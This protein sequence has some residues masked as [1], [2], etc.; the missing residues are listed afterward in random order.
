M[1]VIVFW[2]LDP[3]GCFQ[4]LLDNDS[5]PRSDVRIFPEGFRDSSARW[6]DLDNHLIVTSAVTGHPDSVQ[7]V[8]E[9]TQDCIVQHQSLSQLA[10]LVQIVILLLPS[11]QHIQYHDKFFKAY[12]RI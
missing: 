4:S 1:F 10:P 5:S 8:Q 9:P 7:V 12:L 3:K 6:R 2:L 11:V